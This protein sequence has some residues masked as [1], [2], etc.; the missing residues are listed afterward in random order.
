VHLEREEG[1][2]RQEPII[3][4]SEISQF[5]FCAHAWWLAR[6]KG[7]QSSNLRAMQRGSK[8]HRAHGRRV[9]R[10]H[11]MRQLAVGFLVLALL[12]LA[13]WVAFGVGS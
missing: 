7:Y 10:A 4:A 3:R 2:A 9:E 11:R 8:R 5:A 13:V 1:V 6:V 12:I